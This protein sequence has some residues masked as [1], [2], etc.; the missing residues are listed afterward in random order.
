[1]KKLTELEDRSRLNNIQA[2]SE[3]WESC[4]EE[5]TKIIKN[6]LDISDNIEI[7]CCQRMGKF[8]KKNKSKPPSFVCKFLRSKDNHKVYSISSKTK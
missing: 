6:K 3:T 8:Q 4:E 1:M 2:S 7:D 5:V